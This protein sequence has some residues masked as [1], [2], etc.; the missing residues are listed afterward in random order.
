MTEVFEVFRGALN[1]RLEAAGIVLNFMF[2]ADYR[3]ED[4]NWVITPENTEGE[5][6]RELYRKKEIIKTPIE[7]KANLVQKPGLYSADDAILDLCD[8][9]IEIQEWREAKS[10]E[11]AQLE[12]EL[13]KLKD[14]L[15]IANN[16]IQQ[17]TLGELT[18]VCVPSVDLPRRRCSER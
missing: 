14:L 3:K 17:I 2:K 18:E 9:A 4:D 12:A 8:F 1:T 13:E 11:V 6:L 16:Q 15:A 10:H 7:I 5:K